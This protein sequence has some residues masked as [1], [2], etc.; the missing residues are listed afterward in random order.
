MEVALVLSLEHHTL[1]L[2]EVEAVF[3]AEGMNYLVKKDKEGLL[4]LDLPDVPS[5]NLIK[6]TKRLSF[7]HELFKILIRADEDRIIDEAKKYPWNEHIKSDFAVRV[8]KMDKK[9]SFDSSNLE[10][11]MGRIIKTNLDKKAQVNLE[12]PS[13]LIRI[14]LQD[15]KALIGYRIGKISKKHFFNLKPHK[16]PFFYPGSMSPKLARCMVNL[17]RIHGGETLL[18]PFCGTGG[19]LIEAGIIGT[20]VIGAD[21]DYKMVKGTKK[22]LQHCGIHDFHVFQEDARKL[23]LSNKVD[24]IVTDP[25]YGISA[26]TGGEKSESLY[27]QSMIS[28]EGL[29]KDDGLM[30]L[31]TPHYLD[32]DEVLMGTKFKIIEQHHIRMHKSLTRVISVLGKV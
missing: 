16:R 11:E 13:F 28:L 18:D 5:E 7:T 3:D 10:W 21:I 4:I 1:P 14:V 6:I 15:G 31:A 26:S 19:I 25:P 9:S 22:N 2:A 29:L 12:N 23:E 8:K 20:R 27:Q 24:A 30:C 17:T 32:L